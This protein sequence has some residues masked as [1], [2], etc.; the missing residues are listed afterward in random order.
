MA[1]A[2]STLLCASCAKLAER[3]QDIVQ[4][5]TLPDLSGL[6]WVEDDLFIGVHDAKRTA[7]QAAWPRISLVKL[8]TSELE[9]VTWR[10]LK[11]SFPG[12]DGPSSD[13]ESASRL[14]G[15]RGFVFAESGQAGEGARRLF[16]A[17]YQ[18]GAL[19]IAHAIPWPVPVENVEAMEVCEV[20][21]QPVFLY[22]ERAEGRPET[23]LRWATLSL[24][25][26]AFGSFE[27]VTYV[28][29]DPVGRG[30]RPI[31]ALTV[32]REGL[33]YSASAYDSGNDEGPFR[34][35]VWRIGRI[36]AD[37]QGRPRVRLERGK[38]LATLDG[39][40]VE[41]LAVRESKAGGKQVFVGTDDEH[42]GGL[43]RRL[44]TV[45]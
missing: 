5:T 40:K 1:I 31:V 25:P 22:A 24:D 13:L 38:R 41:S 6:A 43:V 39:L 3:P 9:G 28:G 29:V 7:K 17:E 14:P 37:A 26:V 32:D 35:V 11:I 30:A 4:A 16:F 23:K 33:I 36:L 18:A 8:P 19:N 10:S 34:S 15:G 12:P 21:G 42:Y 20:A 45:R 44:P 27:E 2:L